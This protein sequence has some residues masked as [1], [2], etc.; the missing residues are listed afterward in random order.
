MKL[1]LFAAL[2][3][4]PKQPRERKIPKIWDQL[5][6]ARLPWRHR[7]LSPTSITT[8]KTGSGGESETS[9]FHAEEFLSPRLSSSRIRESF[10]CWSTE[11]GSSSKQSF[12]V[13]SKLSNFY[14]NFKSRLEVSPSEKN[15]IT[16]F[17]PHKF[18]HSPHA[19]L[20]YLSAI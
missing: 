2:F 15:L 17:M 7:S 19:R 14:G 6:V 4:E 13:K 18:S 10:F 3:K 1:N 12:S 11:T 20:D 8:A 5:K 16:T 9:K